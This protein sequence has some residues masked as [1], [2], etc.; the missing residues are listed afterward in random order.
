MKTRAPPWICD[1]RFWGVSTAT[2]FPLIDDDDAM[3]GLFDFG[4]DVRGQNNRVAVRKALDQLSHFMNLFRV[5][6]NGGFVKDQNRRIIE[7]RLCDPD[8]LLISL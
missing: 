6:T 7:Q 4:Q 2:I 8:A 1:R 3:A 5:E